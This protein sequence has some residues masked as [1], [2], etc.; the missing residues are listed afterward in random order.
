M[1]SGAA[2]IQRE[3]K[4]GKITFCIKWRDHDGRQCWERL[5]RSRQ[6]NETKAQRELGKRLEQVEREQWRKPGGITFAAFAERFTRD[7]LRAAGITKPF[8]PW[9]DL[10]HTALTHEAA[11]G[12]PHA[13]VQAKAG[14]SQSTITD[15]YIHAAQVLFPG[16][17]EK[18]EARMFAAAR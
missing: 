9:H 14:H 4:H 18:A 12:N 16:A 7:H 11:A 15:R 8:R 5:G 13:Y 2:V 3:G 6:W 1:A 17:A 10:R